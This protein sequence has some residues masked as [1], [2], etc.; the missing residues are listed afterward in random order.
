[1]SST[2]TGSVS[3][4]DSSS[5]LSETMLPSSIDLDSSLVTSGTSLASSAFLSSLG[6]TQVSS[7][8][9]PLGSSIIT[10]HSTSP[11]SV[12]NPTSFPAASIFPSLPSLPVT[13]VT[14]LVSIKLDTDNFLTWKSQSISL[15]LST[16]HMGFVDG[17]IPCP[18][19]FVTDAEGR[20]VLNPAF[21]DWFRHDQSVRSWLF[22]TVSQ[23]VLLDVHELPTSR[24]IWIA[25]ERRYL[26]QSKAREMKLKFDLLYRDQNDGSISS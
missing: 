22:A 5:P 11:S 9:F 26:D 13:N 2:V 4:A 7:Q 15:L 18:A 16:E 19:Q 6:A 3:T 17:T 12:F 24:E 14:Q 1:M 10:P 21:R 25:L 23:D 20:A 8:P